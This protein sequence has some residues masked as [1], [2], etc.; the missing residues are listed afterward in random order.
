M[1]MVNFSGEHKKSCFKYTSALNRLPHMYTKTV[2]EKSC[3]REPVHKLR[4]TL[5]MCHLCLKSVVI[6]KSK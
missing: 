4:V 6:L 3:T 2:F 1:L 5:K